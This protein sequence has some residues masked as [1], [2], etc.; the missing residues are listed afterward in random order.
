VLNSGEKSDDHGRVQSFQIGAEFVW[1]ELFL[2]C[3][4]QVEIPRDRIRDRLDMVH[5][6]REIEVSRPT[7]RS[8]AG[9][10]FRRGAPY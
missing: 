9:P 4:I 5:L 6:L 8:A 3:D 2:V 7:Q 1:R 10:Y